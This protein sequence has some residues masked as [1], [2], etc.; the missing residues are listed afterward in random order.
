MDL[1]KPSILYVACAIFFK[2]VN[3]YLLYNYMVNIVKNEKQSYINR[4]YFNMSYLRIM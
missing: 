2:L 4:K 3:Q 1:F